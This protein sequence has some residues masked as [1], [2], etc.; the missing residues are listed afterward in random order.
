MR[1]VVDGL[2]EDLS[3]ELNDPTAVYPLV[4][5]LPQV[6]RLGPAVLEEASSN[7]YITRIRGLPEVELFYTL[8]YTNTSQATPLYTNP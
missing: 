7:R 6:A 2:M 4:K 5:L 3:V 1:T 8:I